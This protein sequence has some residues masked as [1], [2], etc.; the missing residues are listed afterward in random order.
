MAIKSKSSRLY[1]KIGVLTLVVLF[2]TA[3]LI[4]NFYSRDI[5]I[6]EESGFR[7]LAS[8][9]RNVKQKLDLISPGWVYKEGCSGKGGV[10]ERDEP[11]YC[12]I[13]LTNNNL[14]STYS[15]S[16]YLEFSKVVGYSFTEVRPT[17]SSKWL[18]SNPDDARTY[19]STGFV[20]D[21]FP[22]TSCSLSEFYGDKL[23]ET[24]AYGV[25][26]TCAH[27]ATRFYFSR[28]DL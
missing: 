8:N 4:F 1:K 28:L 22:E 16:R 24:K 12:S 7:K 9:M 20:Y 5:P 2:F 14:G 17:T 19:N 6:K 10:Y 11:S 27:T 23:N 18:S 15:E 21:D 13:T 3:I 25:N 26:F